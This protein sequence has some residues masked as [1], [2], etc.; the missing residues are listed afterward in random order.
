[1]LLDILRYLVTQQLPDQSDIQA[2]CRFSNN[3]NKFK[4]QHNT[5]VKLMPSGQHLTVVLKDPDKQDIL[6]Q[7]HDD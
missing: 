7:A 5:L 4:I 2:Y 6:Q 3:V 1:M